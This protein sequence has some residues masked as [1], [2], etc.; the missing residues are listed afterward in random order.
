MHLK[1]AKKKGFTQDEIDEAAWLGI[2]FGGS[3]TMVFYEQN[4]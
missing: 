1:N 2:S 4:K 3:H